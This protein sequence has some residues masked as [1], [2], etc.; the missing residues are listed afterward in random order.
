[1]K[2]TK[3]MLIAAL[4][5][6]ALLAGSSVLRAQNATN[7]PPAGEHGP[8]MKGRANIAKQ[9][10]LSDDQKPKVEA[11]MKGAMEKGRALR[12]DTSLTPEEKKDKVKAIKDDMATQL[13]TVLT[14]EQF[15]KWQ[16]LSKRGPRNHPPAG[17]ADSPKPQAAAPPN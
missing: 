6:G 12:E 5:A 8:G 9:L 2:S 3:T 10:D 16:E 14:P 11:I 7:T 1:M 13:K 15:A 17:S 4:A